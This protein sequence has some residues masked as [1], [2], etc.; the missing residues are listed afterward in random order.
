MLFKRPAHIYEDS[1][2]E[3]EIFV[4]IDGKSSPL[5]MAAMLVSC[6]INET[7]EQMFAD[8]GALLL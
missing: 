7:S 2:T 1:E 8:L 4:N 3:L 5:N 6:E